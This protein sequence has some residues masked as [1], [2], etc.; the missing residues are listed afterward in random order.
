MRWVTFY[1]DIIQ[2]IVLDI[3]EHK[4]KDDALKHFNCSYKNYFELATNFKADTLPASYGYPFRK[5]Y[6]IS[7][8]SFKKMFGIGIDEALE[9]SKK[10]G[11]S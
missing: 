5:F 4:N 9:I 3:K 8:R 7:A 6:G 11:E 1:Y 2:D 10:E